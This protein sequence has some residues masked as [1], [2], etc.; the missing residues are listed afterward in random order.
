MGADS[1]W[2]SYNA[3]GLSASSY[4]QCCMLDMKPLGAVNDEGGKAAGAFPPGHQAEF[5]GKSI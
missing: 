1:D 3:N 2:F 5:L 4:A